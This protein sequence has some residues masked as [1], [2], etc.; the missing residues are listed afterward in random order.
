MIRYEV[1][2]DFLMKDYPTFI[3][4]RAK[5]IHNEYG[6]DAADAYTLIALS[7]Y[8]DL[9]VFDEEEPGENVYPMIMP[10]K[11]EGLAMLAEAGIIE[12]GENKI[13]V[14]S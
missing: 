7:A 8:I 3:D 2:F 9:P 1:S 12:I 6:A 5:E 11:S 4:K 13:W 10:V 14:M